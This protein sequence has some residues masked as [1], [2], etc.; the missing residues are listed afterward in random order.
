[1]LVDV[2]FHEHIPYFS[3][4]VVPA[5]LAPQV[6]LSPTPISF[7]SLPPSPLDDLQIQIALC[8]GIQTCT[9]RP[10]SH[11]VS[12]DYLHPTY[13]TYALSVMTASLPKSYCE[14]LQVPEWKAAMDVEYSALAQC[15]TWQLVLCPATCNVVSCRWVYT[16]K[17]NPDGLIVR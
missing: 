7:T 12:Y 15:E 13:H 17:Y 3:L 6:P 4:F 5:P 16:L 14:A 2:T 1:M 9:Q 11:F 8:Q 10:I